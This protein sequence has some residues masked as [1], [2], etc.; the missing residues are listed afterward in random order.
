MRPTVGDDSGVDQPLDPVDRHA[1]SIG[2]CSCGITTR[3]AGGEFGGD[4]L[5]D[6]LISDRFRGV[7]HVDDEHELAADPIPL[8]VFSG[9]SERTHPDLFVQLRQLATQRDTPIGT[10]HVEQVGDRGGDSLWRLVQDRRTIG[11]GNRSQSIGAMASSPRQETLEDEPAALVTEPARH[12]GHCAG[13][14]SGHD[15]HGEPASANSPDQERPGIRQRRHPGIADER[16]DLAGGD[17][18]DE[19]RRADSLHVGIKTQQRRLDADMSEEAPGSSGVLT[20]NDRCSGER[21]DRSL[22]KVAEVADRGSNDHEPSSDGPRL[23]AHRTTTRSPI[24][25]PHEANDPTSASSTNRPR[26]LNRLIRYGRIERTHSTSSSRA[27][28]GRRHL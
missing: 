2:N 21:I 7:R 15:L 9:G 25:R 4:P 26:R 6:L 3:R 13:E 8:E 18:P 19:F 5:T 20:G 14:G 23:A 22:G 16:H 12:E 10:A 24:R 28:S 27:P 17:E 1:Q 11:P